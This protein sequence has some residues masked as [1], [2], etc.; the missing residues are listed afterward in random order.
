MFKHETFDRWFSAF[1]GLTKKEILGL[2]REQDKLERSLGGIKEMTGLPDVMFV[3]DVD[4]EDIAIREARKLGIPVVAIVDTNCS[5][6]GVDYIVPGN[7]DAM[8]AAQLYTAGVAD[9][10][11]DTT[12]VR[13][14]DDVSCRSRRRHGRTRIETLMISIRFLASGS[15]AARTPHPPFCRPAKNSSKK[16]LKFWNFAVM[17]AG[18]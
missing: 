11:I 12:P 17:F 1:E 18:L 10:R 5:P 9:A 8:R 7:D 2:N 16:S 6:E 13:K 15:A 3:V 14:A 4:H